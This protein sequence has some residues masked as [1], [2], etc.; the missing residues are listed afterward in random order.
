MDEKIKNLL[1]KMKWLGHDTFKITNKLTIYTDPYNLKGELEKGDL[2]LVTH[3]HYDHFSLEDIKKIEKDDTVIVAPPD[4]A[5][6]RSNIISI[7]VGERKELKGVQIQAVPAYNIGK[8]FHPKRNK[9]VGYIFIVDNVRIYHAGD[10]D[11]IP[12]MEDFKCDIALLPVSGIYVM[13][14]DEAA[15][16]ALKINPKVAVPMHYGSIVGSLNDAKKFK[17]KLEGKIEVYIFG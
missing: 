9:W 7:E 17:E 15:E 12:E 5:R 16:A 10:T 11:I 13:T 1:S 14:P 4:C 8:D 6:K 2:I 3:D